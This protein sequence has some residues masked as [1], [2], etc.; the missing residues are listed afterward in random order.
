M[1]R[2]H[3]LLP[4][5]RSFS[6]Q[7]PIKI[8]KF[9]YRILFIP[10]NFLFVWRM[11]PVNTKSKTFY[12]IFFSVCPWLG[13]CAMRCESSQ[14]DNIQKEKS[15][16]KWNRIYESTG[17]GKELWNKIQRKFKSIQKNF[18]F[19]ATVLECFIHLYNHIVNG[20]CV[21]SNFVCFAFAVLFRS[22]FFSFLFSFWNQQQR[23]KF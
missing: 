17:N 15:E 8:K 10:Y 4:F 12:H 5:S 20:S 11:F 18:E 23:K 9:H 2:F 13:C 22:I 19:R 16:L 1:L 14:M 7:F 21:L 3:V 6:F